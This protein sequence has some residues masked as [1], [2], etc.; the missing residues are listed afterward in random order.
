MAIAVVLLCGAVLLIRSF[1][2]LHELNPGFDTRNLLTVQVSFAGQKYATANAASQVARRAVQEVEA[3]PGVQ[4]AAIVSTKPLDEGID[5]IF[6]IPGRP[7]PKNQKFAG[8]EM[9]RFVSSHYFQTM[10]IPLRA[11]R[12]FHDDE[13]SHTVV[14]NEAMAKKFWAKTNPIGQSIDIGAGLPDYE[15]GA[16][17][18]IGVVGNVRENGLDVDPPP[19]F[20]QLYS[21]V[22]D[23]ALKLV[24]SLLAP[25]LLI[26]TQPGVSPMSIAGAVKRTLSSAETALPPAKMQTMEQ[27]AFDST[28][29]QNFTLLLLGIF[30]AIA[31]LL[32]ALGVYGVMSYAVEQR[33]REIGVRAALGASRSDTLVLVLRQ[34]F[35][36]AL[37]GVIAG[38]TA[39]LGLTRLLASQLFGVKPS[40]P[41]TFAAV[42][43]I[44][45]TV[46]LAATVIPAL[47]ASRIDPML[48]LRYE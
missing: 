31:L 35:L 28:A 5:M 44:L 26:R 12:L 23:G 10:R 42:A 3:I 11:G 36:L 2:A 21:Q 25:S 33:T 34:G 15:E 32:A 22:P 41:V 24:N 13:P 45:F 30:A 4:S 20:Y 29:R 14:I 43:T 16:A 48:A 9:W 38:L 40:D 46:A 47:R 1:A 39:A 37:I 19:V 17:E 27:I 8:D 6:N 7:L 18:I